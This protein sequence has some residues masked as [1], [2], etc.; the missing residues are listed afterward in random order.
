M[1]GMIHHNLIFYVVSGEL[2]QLHYCLQVSHC[3]SC[4]A[5]HVP[6]TDSTPCSYHRT[7]CLLVDA[8]C[9][10]SVA[11]FNVEFGHDEDKDMGDL[12]SSRIPP[13]LGIL[14]S[15]NSNLPNLCSLNVVVNIMLYIL[16]TR[17]LPIWLFMGSSFAWWFPLPPESMCLMFSSCMIDI[18]WKMISFWLTRMTV[19]IH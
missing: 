19:W 9:H 17:H 18:G 14:L 8:A 15:Y 3:H 6:P 11:C 7:P 12:S 1:P 16:R 13:I 5:Y 2:I 10:F 4:E